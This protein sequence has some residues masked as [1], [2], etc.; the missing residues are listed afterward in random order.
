MRGFKS[1]LLRSVALAGLIALPLWT[2]PAAAMTLNEAVELAITTNPDVGS[3][4]NNRRAIDEELRQGRAL[5]LPQVDLRGATGAEYSDNA[6][7]LSQNRDHR[8]LWRKEASAT[9]SQL[10]FD[11]FF[12][13]SEVEKQI[14]RVESAAHRVNE[15]S[16]FTGLDA[17]ESYLEVLRHRTRVVIAEGNVTVHRQRLDQVRTRAEAGGGNIA[18]VRQA[19]ARLSNAESSLN[20]VR[21]DLRDAEALFIRV[22]GQAPDT[23]EDPVVP[24]DVIPQ[25]VETAVALAIENSPTVQ[26][27]R[28]D[29]KAAEAD[30]KQQNASLYPDVRLEIGGSANDDIDGR[31]GDEYDA[32]ALLVLRYNLYRGGADVA[33]IRE[34]KYRQAEALDRLRQNERKVAEDTRVSWNAME[35][36]RN[37]VEILR[38]EVEAN[39]RTRD[40]YKQQFEIGQRGLLDLLDA[41]NELFLAQ[42]SLVTAEYTELF[43]NYRLL[44]SQGSLQ[45]AL[46][47]TPIEAANP[48]AAESWSPFE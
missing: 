37:N 27:A 22:V 20:Q 42:D 19:E 21:G 38:R 46:G 9:L 13:D 8:T 4:A 30:V 34:F 43:A 23:L 15:A 14:A 29:V 48:Q 33:R 24:A 2:G 16:E 1:L 3:V 6:T 44:A 40:V 25:D 45:R 10:L 28:S 7:T 11:G 32:T 41:D 36:S 12:A 18:D 26:F 47:L 17:V 35:V 31:D 39:E 5:Y